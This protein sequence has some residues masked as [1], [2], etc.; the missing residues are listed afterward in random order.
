[1]ARIAV[2]LVYV[3]ASSVVVEVG[4]DYGASAGVRIWPVCQVRLIFFSQF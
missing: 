1:M 2:I 4:P 3:W